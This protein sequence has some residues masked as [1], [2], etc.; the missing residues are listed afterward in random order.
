MVFEGHDVVESKRY[1]LC[2]VI[3]RVKQMYHANIKLQMKH[4]KTD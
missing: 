1:E 2:S 3:V 4:S